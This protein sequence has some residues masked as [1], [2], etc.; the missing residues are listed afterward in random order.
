MSGVASLLR[1]TL[2]SLLRRPWFSAA[3]IATMALGIGPNV[4]IY[5]MLRVV[6]LTPLPFRDVDGLVWIGHRA[7]GGQVDEELGMTPGLY[8]LYTLDPTRTPGLESMA[9]FIGSGTRLTGY[10]EPLDLGLVEAT[11]NLPRV[12]GIEP[13]LGRWFDD[14]DVRR[15]RAVAVLGDGLWRGHFGADTTVVGRSVTLNDV[16]TEIVGVM[17]PEFTGPWGG[18]LWQPF[19]IDGTAPF[20]IDQPYGGFRFG[21]VGRLSEL[22]ES[23]TVAAELA[24]RLPAVEELYPGDFARFVLEE[25]RLRPSVESL[26]VRMR[27]GGAVVAPLLMVATGFVL[28]IAITNVGGLLLIR[29]RNRDVELAI[30]AALGA[31]RVRQTVTVMAES[32]ALCALGGGL[33]AWLAAV[34]GGSIARLMPPSGGLPPPGIDGRL[35]TLAV[36]AG[37]LSGALC[38]AG[39]LWQL[40]RSAL[41]GRPKPPPTRPHARFRTAFIATQVAIALV[42]LV[43][44]GLTLRTLRNV[45]GVDLGFEAQGALTFETYLIDVN[46]AEAAAF[47]E[48]LLDRLEALPGVRSA[49]AARCLPLV[50]YCHVRNAVTAEAGSDVP[51]TS[52]SSVV[53]T[54][55]PGYFRALGSPIIA[56]RGFERG[57]AGDVVLVSRSL[58]RTLWGDRSAVGQR[59]VLGEGEEAR[60]M[61]VVGVVGDLRPHTL[62]DGR[63]ETHAVYAPLRA[64]VGR[65]PRQ[66]KFVVRTTG[67]P[68]AMVQ[69]VRQAVWSLDADLPV[70][71]VEPLDVR[72]DVATGAERGLAGLLLTFSLLAVALSFVGVFSSVSYLVTGRIVELG[73]RKALGAR[74]DQIFA[75]VLGHGLSATALGLALGTVASALLVRFIE[76]MLFGVTPSDARTYASGAVILLLAS[77]TAAAIPALRA[78][79]VDAASSLRAE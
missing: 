33:G 44:A 35:V 74:S 19:V 49:G 73:V 20:R 77:C 67:D 6:L 17:P 26:E 38:T 40:R 24:S 14:E 18:Q 48:E 56:G 64:N 75:R 28:L 71:A 29:T 8:S 39:P 25:A 60:W 69:R 59:L 22:G 43:G 11:P 76:S 34:F 62:R 55:T 52:S 46:R 15:G 37:V 32:V 58:A 16:P 51:G 70:S 78:S 21:A 30:R 65:S 3:V 1:V 68:E 7:E 12:L 53:N 2:R 54:A 50:V 31:G 41:P 9:M 13:Q 63:I 66:M 36:L 57:E 4:A 79:R 45:Q 61:S 5:G 42:L 27:R 47:Q 72:L 23:T 10:G